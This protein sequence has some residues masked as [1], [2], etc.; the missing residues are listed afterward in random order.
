M[1]IVVDTHAWIEF[2]TGSEEGAKVKEL[3]ASC[4]AYV[5]DIV[6]AEVA[7]KYLKE[8]VDEEVVRERVEWITDVARRVS[9]DEELALLSAK[10]YFELLERARK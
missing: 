4:E 8:G 2:F 1:K 9:I 6:L 3:L 10:C 5:P 7:R